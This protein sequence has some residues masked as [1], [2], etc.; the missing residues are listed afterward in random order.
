[1][2]EFLFAQSPYVTLNDQDNVSLNRMV[3]PKH[4]TGQ[5]L[6]PLSNTFYQPPLTTSPVVEV[7]LESTSSPPPSIMSPSSRL[8]G[9]ATLL[10]TTRQFFSSC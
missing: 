1:M 4:F 8:S 10:L 7:Q 5:T 3:G 9:Q 6:C 2:G